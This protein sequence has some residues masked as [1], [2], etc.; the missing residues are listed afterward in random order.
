VAIQN[1]RVV[2]QGR[3]HR[4]EEQCGSR[5]ITALQL[6]PGALVS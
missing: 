1:E 5:E 2:I 3:E 6:S 4:C